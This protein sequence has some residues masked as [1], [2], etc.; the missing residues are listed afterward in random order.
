VELRIA[1][2]VGTPA[3]RLLIADAAGAWTEPVQPTSL[4]SSVQLRLPSPQAYLHL[5]SRGEPQQLVVE[6]VRA[7]M[8]RS[9]A[10]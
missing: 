3:P 6:V 9:H 2:S 8:T 7:A 10:S 5:E 4:M 1:W